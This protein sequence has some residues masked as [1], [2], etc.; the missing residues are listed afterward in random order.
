MPFSF[1]YISILDPPSSPLV[2][3]SQTDISCSN[4]LI[5][6]STPSSDRSITSYSVYLNNVSIYTGSDNQYTDN[7][8]LNISTVYE[9][10]VVAV[11][12]AGNSTAGVKSISL[13]SHSLIDLGISYENLTNEVH[14]DWVC[15]YHHHTI[16]IMCFIL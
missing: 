8:Q 2:T 5:S 16:P 13:G 7:T 6:W 15:P 12:C 14:I 9:Y 1:V 4:P 11:S 3:L 10:S